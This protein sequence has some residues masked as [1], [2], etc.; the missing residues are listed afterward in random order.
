M[1]GHI[2]EI[3]VKVSIVYP[4]FWAD[5]VLVNKLLIVQIPIEITEFHLQNFGKQW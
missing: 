3:S 2:S 5:F 4:H 1:C